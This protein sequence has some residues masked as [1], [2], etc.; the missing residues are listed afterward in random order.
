VANGEWRV[1]DGRTG[2]DEAVHASTSRIHMKEMKA[3][4]YHEDGGGESAAALNI[5]PT[6]PL[7]RPPPPPPPPPTT[8]GTS[9][10]GGGGSFPRAHPAVAIF[11]FSFLFSFFFSCLDSA[12]HLSKYIM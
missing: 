3:G 5:F 7:A 4:L 1:A 6:R 8:T 2:G 10:G 12:T 9:L 11:F